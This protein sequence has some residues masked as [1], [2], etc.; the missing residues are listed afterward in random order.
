MSSTP[1]A[2]LCPNCEASLVGEYCHQCGQQVIAP[3]HYALGHFL[4]HALHDLTHFDSKIFRSLFPLVF[5]PGF[6]TAQYLA[7]RQKSY[8]KPITMFVLVNLVFFLVVHR[9]GMLNWTMT[10]VTR[11]PHGVFAKRLV[12]EKIAAQQ[13]SPEAFET[14]F[15]QVLRY[16]QKSMFFFLIPLF[17]VALKGFYLRQRRYYVEHLI[18][19]IHFHSYYLIFV[20][21]GMPLLML[22]LGVFDLAFGTILARTFGNDPYILVPLLLGMM[23][24]LF[25]GLRRVQRQSFLVT[26]VKTLLLT[27]GEFALIALVIQPILFFMT[28]FA[29]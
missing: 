21:I 1:S 27:I 4:K 14:R 20:V 25:L 12:A 10:G 5:K 28:Y 15:N 6:L 26:S 29:V 11:G 8:I 3:H 7:G 16:N 13:V 18:F 17:A 24:Y 23:V 9:M 19:S 22:V 2:T